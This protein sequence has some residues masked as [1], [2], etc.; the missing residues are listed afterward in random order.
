MASEFTAT[1]LESGA[2]TLNAVLSD[3]QSMNAG[4]DNVQ[5]VSTDN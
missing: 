4:F 3:S 1:F 5:V 2:K